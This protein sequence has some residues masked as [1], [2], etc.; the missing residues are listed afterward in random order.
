MFASLI[1]FTT[2][3]LSKHILNIV[4]IFIYWINLL[5]IGSLLLIHWEYARKKHLLN[6]EGP[7]LVFVTNAIR[8]RIYSAQSLYLVGAFLSFIHPYLSIGFIIFI[9]LNFAFGF[10]SRRTQNLPMDEFVHRE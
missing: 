9:Q 6:I 7:N 8:R 5:S 2:D 10:L 1:P 4:S 3:I